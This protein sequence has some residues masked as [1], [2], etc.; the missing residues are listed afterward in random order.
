[1]KMSVGQFMLLIIVVIVVIAGVAYGVVKM[2]PTTSGGK[3]RQAVFLNNGQ[4]YFGYLSGE[5]EEWIT[6]KDIYY[7]QVQQA[8]QPPKDG[9]QDQPQISLVKLGNE[10]HGPVDEMK[11]NH[12]HIIFYESM[13]NDSKVNQAIS[14]F[15]KNGGATAP[16]PSA[17]PTK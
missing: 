6:L 15:I 14:D 13:K 17:T 8:L 4:V 5:N 3:T 1:M 9:A 12:E 10:L 11:I 2:N 7:L 16:V